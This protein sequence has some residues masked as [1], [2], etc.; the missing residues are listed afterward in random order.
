MQQAAQSGLLSE[1]I[2]QVFGVSDR[3]Q[4]LAQEILEIA[5]GNTNV[6]PV[7]KVV[8]ADTLHGHLGAYAEASNTIFLSDS[9]IEIPDLAIEVLT[10]EFGHSIA[11]RY[12]NDSEQSTDA[13]AFTHKV[14]GKDFA[15]QL[16][17]PEGHQA[18]DSHAQGDAL[19]PETTALASDIKWF[20]T[21]L[22]IDW[23]RQQLPMLNAQAFEIFRVAQNDSDAF[24]GPIRAPML[25]PYGLQTSSATH[26][27]NNNIRGSIETMRKRW[28]DGIDNFN[29][30]DIDFRIF[31]QFLDASRVGPAFDGPN[32]GVENLM[33]RFGQIS[34][35]FQ[36]FYSHSNWVEMVRAGDGKWIAP[37]ALLDTGFDLPQQ[38]NPGSYLTN[39]PRVMVA[40]SGSDFD[41]TLQEAGTGLFLTGRKAVH[42]WVTDQQAGWGEV[43]ANPKPGSE[44]YGSPVGALMTGA[45]NGA[46]YYDTDYSV[47]LRAPNKTGI[48]DKEYFNGF[49]HGGFAG[50]M[51]GRSW[52]SPLS[53]DKPDNG[54]FSD[55][56]AN[57]ALFT[58]AQ[59]YAGLQLR[60]DFDRLGNM[61]FKNYGEAGLRKFANYAITENSRE[62]FVTTYSTPGGR[63]KWDQT[64]P[65][66]KFIQLLLA[67]SAEDPTALDHAFDESAMRFVE[68]FYPPNADEP[69]A[70]PQRAYLTQILKDGRW[71]DSSGGLINTHHDH[72]EDYGPEAFTPAATQHSAMGGRA[73]WSL[74]QTEE[75]NYLGTIYYVANINTGAR[76]YLDEFDVS[77]D[78]LH[79]VDENGN[80]IQVV[81]LD[82]ADY[83]EL[84]QRLLNLYNIDV[85][86]RPEEETFAN[87]VV[88]K[89]SETRGPI[90]LQ[91]ADFFAD[92]DLTVGTASDR[93]QVVHSNLF[94]AGHDETRSWLKLRT[95]GLLEITDISKAPKGTHEIFVS[96]SDGSGM[97]EGVMITLAIDPEVLIAGR[98]YAPQTQ[99]ELRF[100]DSGDSSISV[101]GQVVDRNGTPLAY[102]EHMGSRLGSASGLPP[103]ANGTVVQTNLADGIDSGNFE[104]FAYLY[105]KQQTVEL[106]VEPTSGDRFLLKN[107]QQTI[108][109]LTLSPDKQVTTYTDEIYINALEDVLLGVPLR[110]GLIQRASDKKGSPYE[111]TLQT[112]V[113]REAAHDGEFGFILA[114]PQNGYIIE[115]STGLHIEEVSLN[116]ENIGQFSVY[117]VRGVRDREITHSGSFKIDP[118]LNLNN[119]ALFPYYRAENPDGAEL[120]IGRSNVD[121]LSHI[122]RVGKNTFGVEDLVGGDY[123]FDDVVITITGMTVVNTGTTP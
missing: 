4:T 87:S 105:D 80:T 110:T 71:W 53:K 28:G 22:H 3:Q 42:W 120:F 94:F 84:H 112:S 14:L 109:E 40:M 76:V 1:A 75:G 102:A 61:I 92:Q 51:P 9:L 68:V 85:N 50:A 77:I 99:A 47:P 103:G 55:K 45:V 63:W 25:S 98:A 78:E 93:P 20:D 44:K 27:D 33:Y 117:S 29:S 11:S 48:L 90:L 37:R 15:L 60:A 88:I 95:D 8:P 38:L 39:A 13:Y 56:T 79:L 73:V 5:N 24:F 46:I 123:D 18:E 83:P 58:E 7:L 34:H 57:S 41:A 104:F 26:F 19:S 74:P 118:E 81:D 16:S 122:S 2:A 114:D 66:Q 62:L 49:S 17:S 43:Y 108:A 72:L 59:A 86:S 64:D 100:T 36:D 111:V 52:I 32:A 91:A 21:P 23:A 96:V 101:Y 31:V 115:P 12:F 35:A 6:L 121:G 82:H 97:L 30:T 119:L 70:T 10:H 54:R 113:S 106:S 65:A 107:G 67:K 116:P 69:T 89:S